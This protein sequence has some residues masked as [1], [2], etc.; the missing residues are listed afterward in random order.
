MTIQ[1]FT[2][3]QLLV[4]YKDDC[5]IY[6]SV[7]TSSPEPW[8]APPKFREDGPGDEVDSVSMSAIYPI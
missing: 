1:L 2:T 4:H 3:I 6:Y 8:E 7:A 5:A